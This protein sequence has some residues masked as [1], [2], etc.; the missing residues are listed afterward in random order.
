MSD[1]NKRT[2]KNKE[3]KVVANIAYKETEATTAGEIMEM[4]GCIMN[5]M[6]AISFNKITG[7]F[8][9]PV[10]FTLKGEHPQAYDSVVAAKFKNSE[11]AKKAW[12]AKQQELIGLF[13]KKRNEY[14]DLV[15]AGI[16]PN[17]IR[18]ED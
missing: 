13:E 4:E 3:G 16:D 5:L 14:R 9:F 12:V 18:N 10:E 17:Q 11:D 15:A 2:L 6:P 8:E 7:K 1:I